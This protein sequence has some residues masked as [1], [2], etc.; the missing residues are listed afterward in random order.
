MI[1]AEFTPGAKPPGVPCRFR[2]GTSQVPHPPETCAR[3]KRGNGRSC[4][5]EVPNIFYP[6]ARALLGSGRSGSRLTQEKIQNSRNKKTGEWSVPA[7]SIEVL[8]LLTL[9]AIDCIQHRPI[10]GHDRRRTC[11]TGPQCLEFSGGPMCPRIVGASRPPITCGR[12]PAPGTSTSASS[13]AL[14]QRIGRAC[15]SGCRVL[16][17]DNCDTRMD[18]GFACPQCVRCDCD[19][20][21]QIFPCKCRGVRS[22]LALVSGASA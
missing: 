16:D 3:K 4:R 19:N 9:R 8:A 7:A 1:A 10:A 15:A 6:L 11:T 18:K 17:C 21:G 22:C 14:W 2:P 20:C 5:V 13:R 12:P